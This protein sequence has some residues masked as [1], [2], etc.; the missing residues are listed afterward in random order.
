MNDLSAAERVTI[1]R[2]LSGHLQAD[3]HP[4]AQWL[5]ATLA[6]WLR[7]GGD[8]PALLGVRPPRGS[9][10]TAQALVRQAEIEFLMRRMSGDLKS[11]R[12]A[13]EVLRGTRPCPVSCVTARDR[14][15]ELNAPKSASAFRRA[16]RNGSR[17]S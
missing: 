15:I 14:L 1:L 5:G 11:N 7:H 8:L 16:R 17:H 12:I 3:R 9:R 4:G 2:Q 6:R 10:K 13:S